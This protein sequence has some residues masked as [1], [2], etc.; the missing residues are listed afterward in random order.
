MMPALLKVAIEEMGADLWAAEVELAPKRERVTATTWQGINQ[1]VDDVRH[2]LL[3]TALAGSPSR[4][5]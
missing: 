5:G 2:R 1:A 3:A 4:A